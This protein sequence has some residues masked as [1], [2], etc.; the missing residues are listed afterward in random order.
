MVT[1]P[2]GPTLETVPVSVAARDPAPTPGTVCEIVID[3]V[4]PTTGQTPLPQLKL[5]VPKG[6]TDGV[7]G[8]LVLPTLVNATFVVPATDPVVEYVTEVANAIH[9]KNNTST[10]SRVIFLIMN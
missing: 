7:K 1:K 3:R 6:P 8:T 10:A 5:R 9:G 2:K 4:A